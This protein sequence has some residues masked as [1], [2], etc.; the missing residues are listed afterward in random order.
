VVPA[1][2]L[3]TVSA[4]V[5]RGERAN[6][7]GEPLNVG[8]AVFGLGP[9]AKEEVRSVL[10][11][12]YAYAGEHAERIADSAML[13]VEAIRDTV[14]AFESAGCQHLI[15]ASAVPDPAQVELLATAVR[16][17]RVPTGVR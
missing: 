6:R 4:P 13:S 17:K 15:L 10:L 1:P 9:Q 2:L 14:A 5:K 12:Y 11:D 7:P 8:L 16:P 3:N